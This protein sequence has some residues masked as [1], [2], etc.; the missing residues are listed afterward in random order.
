[1]FRQAEEVI[2]RDRHSHLL[3]PRLPLVRIHSA[4]LAAIRLAMSGQAAESFSVLRSAIEQA[5][6]ALHIAKDPKAPER[7]N[8]WLSRNVDDSSK[9]KCK[10]EFTVARVRS[11]HEGLDP[12]TARELQNRYENLID[13]GAHPNQLGLF[14]T[15]KKTKSEKQVDY[16]VGILASDSKAV[17]FALRMAV[18]VAVGGLKVF[19]LIYPERFTIAALGLEIQR[20]VVGLNTVFKPYARIATST[21]EPNG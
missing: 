16:K 17:P 19:N 9:A 3:V 2:E 20:L 1:M 4:F 13:L 21:R 18:A 15:I 14:A 11:T 5:W 10:S 12:E 6:Y 7:A 8:T